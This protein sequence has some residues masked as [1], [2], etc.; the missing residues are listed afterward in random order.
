MKSLKFPELKNDTQP[1][2]TLEEI[3]EINYTTAKMDF[4]W[5]AEHLLPSDNKLDPTV[6]KNFQKKGWNLEKCENRD[7]EKYS[8]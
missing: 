2:S 6:I 7:L 1:R 3:G 4:K 5:L 8:K